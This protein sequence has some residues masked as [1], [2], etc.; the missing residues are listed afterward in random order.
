MAENLYT[1]VFACAD[2]E[3]GVHFNTW[4]IINCAR[5]MCDFCN[6]KKM[7]NGLLKVILNA[8]NGEI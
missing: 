1:W 7:K 5:K 8:E 3:Y 4:G 2:H 6:V